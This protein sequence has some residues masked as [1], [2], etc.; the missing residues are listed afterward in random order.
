MDVNMTLPPHAVRLL[1]HLLH[2]TRNE[3]AEAD[4][5]LDHGYSLQ[6]N[7]AWDSL[8][9]LESVIPDEFWPEPS[10]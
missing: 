9:A 10:E 5:S 4:S 6:Q 7:A 1:A 3:W 2:K 8:N